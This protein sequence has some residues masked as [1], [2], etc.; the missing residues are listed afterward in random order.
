MVF[1]RRGFSV[2]VFLRHISL[3]IVGECHVEDLCVSR[4]SITEFPARKI[5]SSIAFFDHEFFCDDNFCRG[6]FS[7]SSNTI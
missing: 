2:I 6:R 7:L 3:E 5:M 1:V 4:I